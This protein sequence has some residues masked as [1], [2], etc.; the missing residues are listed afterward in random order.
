MQE[1]AGESVAAPLEPIVEKAFEEGRGALGTLEDLAAPGG[2][3]LADTVTPVVLFLPDIPSRNP[4]H[5]FAIGAPAGDGHPVIRFEGG[6]HRAI[7]D[8]VLLRFAAA[9]AGTRA[10]SLPLV[11][12]NGL[13]LT[14]GQIVSLGGDFYGIPDRP[15]SDGTTPQERIDRFTAAYESL[16]TA[17]AAVDEAKQILDVM[18]IEIDAVNAAIAA[19]GSPSAEYAKLGD[20]LSGEWNRITGGGSII[21]S[22]IPP[23]RYLKLAA[24][25]WD[26][27]GYHAVL[28]YQAG[29]AA[30]LKQAAAASGSPE[31]RLE[32]MRAYA[33][34]AFADHYLSDLFSSGHLRT[35]RKE[36]YESVTPSA[37]GSL[38]SRFM[39][40]EDCRWGLIVVNRKPVPERW[41]A[42]GDK[43]YFDMVNA[44]NQQRVDA[45][46]QL[47]VDEVFQ[48]FLTG[49]EPDPET[50][51]ALQAAP[52]LKRVQS[53]LDGA[54]AATG[55]ISPLFLWDGQTV[56]RRNDID[57]LDDYSWTAN[58]VGIATLT[59]LG[60]KRFYNPPPPAAWPTPPLTAPTIAANGWDANSMPPNWV[61]GAQV[62]YAASFLAGPDPQDPRY[63]SDL[64]PWGDYA[65]VGANQSVPTLTDIPV[66]P[67][68]TFERIVYRQFDG[69]AATRVIWLQGNDAEVSFKD[70]VP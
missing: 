9:D 36:L 12:P 47:S 23:G 34:N 61:E 15:I 32:L 28:A 56:Q 20:T 63:E 18:Q 10:G 8:S 39:H 48:A 68:T 11:L 54:A 37:V 31:P 59:K 5:H 44:D 1:P 64:G 19:G 49:K 50:Y 38:L 60:L 69:Q 22:M 27:F 55:H 58:W 29:H 70:E 14:Y 25:N 4:K 52:D 40:D 62:R 13:E 16:A 65:T 24:T 6:E 2:I 66:G 26:H 43:R 53:S 17:P 57:D 33:K 67:P 45:A 46:L 3:G 21:H 42:Y 35:P 7:G 30:A 41:H 51:Q